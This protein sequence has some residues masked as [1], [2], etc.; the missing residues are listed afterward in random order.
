MYSRGGD[1]DGEGEGP[2]MAA[3]PMQGFLNKLPAPSEI[4]M[5]SGIEYSV[6]L[7]TYNERD[8][9]AI[10]TYLIVKAFKEL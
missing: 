8:N 6:L 4:K 2:R 5:P 10:V 1:G 3:H 7:P 9:I